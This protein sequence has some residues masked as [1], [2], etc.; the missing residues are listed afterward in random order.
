MLSKVRRCSP[1]PYPSPVIAATGQTVDDVVV[2][3][4]GAAHQGELA[5]KIL[6]YQVPYISDV[7]PTNRSV[8]NGKQQNSF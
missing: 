8:N 3:C 6:S 5:I 7:A 2:V 1:P 4:G